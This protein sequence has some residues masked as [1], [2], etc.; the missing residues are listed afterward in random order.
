MHMVDWMIDQIKPV[1]VSEC[2]FVEY[3][4]HVEP[5]SVVNVKRPQL[6]HNYF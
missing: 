4:I 6:C 3:I 2:V 5:F 1:A